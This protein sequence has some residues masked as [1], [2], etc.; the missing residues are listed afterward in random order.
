MEKLKEKLD[1]IT[2][3]IKH[4]AFAYLFVVSDDVEIRNYFIDNIS[5][6]EN[7]SVIDDS[8][9]E[10]DKTLMDQLNDKNVLLLNADVKAEQLRILNNRDES[11]NSLYYRLV[12]KREFLWKNRKTIIVVADEK[13]IIPL[14]QENQSLASASSFHFIDDQIKEKKLTKKD[15]K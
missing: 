5:R 10:S 13:T 12:F 11:Y 15:N 9:I 7:V 8:K 4:S 14:L 1:L 6:M 2:Y 3:S